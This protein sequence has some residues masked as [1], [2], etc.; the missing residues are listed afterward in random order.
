MDCFGIFHH[1]ND[2]SYNKKS[3]RYI[4]LLLCVGTYPNTNVYD[5]H[6]YEEV[7]LSLLMRKEKTTLLKGQVD[8]SNDRGHISS[9]TTAPG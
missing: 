9:L 1:G 7:Q 3:S 5:G 8:K 4:P 2:Q 6:I